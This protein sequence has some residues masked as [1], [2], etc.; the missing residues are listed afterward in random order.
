MKDF[1]QLVGRLA[2]E[3]RNCSLRE[4]AARLRLGQLQISKH[5]AFRSIE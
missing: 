5:L 2:R 3:A 4:I 1:Q